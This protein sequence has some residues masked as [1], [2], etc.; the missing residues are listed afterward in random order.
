MVWNHGFLFFHSVGKNHPNWLIFFRGVGIP[1]TRLVKVTIIG[2]RTQYAIHIKNGST[3]LRIIP[4]LLF[5][6]RL[7]SLWNMNLVMDIFDLSSDMFDLSLKDLFSPVFHVF[8]PFFYDFL[9]SHFSAMFSWKKHGSLPWCCQPKK[10]SF[11][12]N[13]WAVC[14]LQACGFMG[15]NVVTL[16]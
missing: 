15:F 7:F 4:L 1:P 5:V 2:F 12:R 14:R 9:T 6:R 13:T 10:P 11:M 8:H 16:W 3:K